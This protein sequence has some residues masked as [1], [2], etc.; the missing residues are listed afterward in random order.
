MPWGDRMTHVTRGDVA[1]RHR[2]VRSGDVNGE[3]ARAIV[4]RSYFRARFALNARRSRESPAGLQQPD[5]TK[6]A[7][8]LDERAIWDTDRRVAAPNDR[9]DAVLARHDGRVA[10]DPARVRNDGGHCC[11]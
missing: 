4:A 11:E 8:H 5:L 10:Q 1:A 9:G 3:P 2:R 6:I 7:V